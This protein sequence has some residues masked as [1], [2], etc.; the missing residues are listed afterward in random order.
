MRRLD[1]LPLADDLLGRPARR[2]AAADYALH[3]VFRH[4][5]QPPVARAHDGLPTLHRHA[6]RARNE[7][8]FLERVS[9]VRHFGGD[10]VVLP[11]VGKRFVVE[12]L[13][14]DF[15]LLF[16]EV[17][18]FLLAEH[19]RAER[20]DL[21]SVVAAPDSEDDAPAGENVGGGVVLREAE[22]MP[23]RGDI[24]PAAELD[25]LGQVRQVDAQLHYVGDALVA[26]RLE[27]VLGHPEHVVAELVHEDAHRL[28][29]V[30]HGGE[31]LVGVEPV[32]GGGGGEANVL[33]V[34]MP[35]EQASELVYHLVSSP[36]IGVWGF[37]S[38]VSPTIVTP[39]TLMSRIGRKR[40][41][42][43]IEKFPRGVE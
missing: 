18:V 23:H 31:A 32:V 24:E 7:A 11:L 9:P 13:E 42:K 27:V 21:A 16:E 41:C 36:V 28:R 6:E 10:C 19:R 22:R 29:L 30:E 12:R 38:A 2:R 3:A 14:Q 33:K 25:S 37:R 20:L 40:A 35:G 4:E 8:Y 43:R 17:A 26:F 34:N 15:H 5:V 39:R 1:F